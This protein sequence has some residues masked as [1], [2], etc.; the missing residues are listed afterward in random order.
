MTMNNNASEADCIKLQ[1][2]MTDL[3][4]QIEKSRKKQ[5]NLF[6][7]SR[8]TA[9]GKETVK[10]TDLMFDKQ[11]HTEACDMLQMLQKAVKTDNWN[12]FEHITV[13]A[14]QAV[15]DDPI[16]LT[17]KLLPEQ[18]D[19]AEVV[20]DIATQEESI[21]KIKEEVKAEALPV[22]ELNGHRIDPTVVEETIR[23]IREEVKPPVKVLTVAA[24]TKPKPKPTRTDDPLTQLL[25][26]KV[27]EYLGLSK[28]DEPVLSRED[29]LKMIEDAQVE[30]A[31]AYMN[32]LPRAVFA[33]AF[34]GQS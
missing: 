10:L 1:S 29:V 22:V 25:A 23:C 5:I 13:P 30:Q 33:R 14:G 9:P 8:Y 2:Q 3:F 12:E 34:G 24:P 15:K 32:Q 17:L 20:P 6:V 19:F 16:S 26:E 27:A 4:K 21:R 11:W 7:S 28:S 18:P 31:V